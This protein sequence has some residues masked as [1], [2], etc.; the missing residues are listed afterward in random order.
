MQKETL[1]FYLDNNLDEIISEKSQNYF[2][3]KDLPKKDLAPKNI[4]QNS[5]AAPKISEPLEIKQIAKPILSTSEALSQLAKKTSSFSNSTQ[6]FMSLNSIIAKAQKLASEAKNLDELRAAVENFDGCNLK[7]MATNTVFCDGNINSEI[8]VIGEAPGNHEDLQGI[9]FCGDSGKLLDEMFRS[10]NLSRDKNLYI[11][12]VIFWRPPGNR[13]PTDE[14]LAICRPFVERHIQ[15]INPKVLVLV[16]STSMTAILG[17][18]DPISSIRGKFMDF[19]PK[20]LDKSIKTFT[21]FHP[22]YLMR[23]HSKKRVAWLDM[24]ALEKFLQR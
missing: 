14:E 21:I 20:F 19:A 13:R 1:Q 6:D 24:L 8:M 16:G 11:T 3:E 22:S 9:P 7:K 18:T 12:N 5:F 10:I 23:Q 15:L 4:A 2:L 17:I